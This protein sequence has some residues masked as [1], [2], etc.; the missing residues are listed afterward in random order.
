MRRA[1]W[2]R[3]ATFRI[4]ER[5][6]FRCR[7]RHMVAI[8]HVDHGAFVE[9]ESQPAFVWQRA[10]GASGSDL[11]KGDL[12]RKREGAAV[13]A[14]RPRGVAELWQ[15]PKP[16]LILCPVSVALSWFAG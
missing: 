8:G 2:K 5:Q 1:L 16:A 7:A 3:V 15:A 13:L 4:G 14:S 11:S 6:S 9:E 12:R 10:L